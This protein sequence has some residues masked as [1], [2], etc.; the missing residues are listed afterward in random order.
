MKLSDY[1]KTR[2]AVVVTLI[3]MIMSLTAILGFFDK[4]NTPGGVFQEYPHIMLS[5]LIFVLTLCMLIYF[6]ATSIDTSWTSW[7]TEDEEP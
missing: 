7:R 1:N 4:L 2:I 6:L 3:F 5:I